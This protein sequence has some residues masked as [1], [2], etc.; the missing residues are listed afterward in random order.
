MLVNE[1]FYSIEGEGSRAGLPCVFIRLFGCNIKCSYCDSQYACEGKGYTEMSVDEIMNKVKAYD[2]PNVTVTGGEPLIHKDITSLLTRLCFAN[3]VVNVETNGTKRPPMFHP[4]LF[5][6]MDFKTKSSGMSD[7]M[8]VNAFSDL[9]YGD[10]LKFVVGSVED[11]D[12][13]VQFCKDNNIRASVFVSPI[14]GEIE[15]STIVEYLKEQK[16]HDWK[17]QL[18]LHKYIWNPQKRGV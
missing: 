8:Y 11:L 5:Y 3:F 1:I 16:L 7:K 10:V 14:F 12:Q 9:R 17:M 6:T 18:Q 2:C 13:A 15:P 4:N